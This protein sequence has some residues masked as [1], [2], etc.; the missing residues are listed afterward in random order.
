MALRGA[1]FKKAQI[2]S[3]QGRADYYLKSLEHKGKTTS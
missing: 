3:S 2:L 1:I